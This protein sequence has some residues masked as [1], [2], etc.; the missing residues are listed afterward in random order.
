[1]KKIRVDANELLIMLFH[2]LTLELGVEKVEI[3]E[4]RVNKKGSYYMLN[5]NSDVL[6]FLNNQ[7]GGDIIDLCE[8]H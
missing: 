1:M 3:V 5:T 2:K 8:I 6:R 7:K 4:C